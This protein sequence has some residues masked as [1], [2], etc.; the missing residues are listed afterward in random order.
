MQ[1]C[2]ESEFDKILQNIL[3]YY[4]EEFNR[5]NLLYYVYKQC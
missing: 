3:I 4:E 5:T 1:F 2:N